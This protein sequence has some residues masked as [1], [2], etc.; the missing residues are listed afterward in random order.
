MLAPRLRLLAA[1]LILAAACLLALRPDARDA[2]READRLF[3][4]GRYY[5]ALAAYESLASG[6]PSAQLRAG[7][8]HA[9]RGERTAAERALRSA[10]Q[11]GLAPA[12]YHLALLYLGRALADDGRVDLAAST[13]RLLEDCRDPA[14]C[15]YVAPG[16]AL[17]ADEAMARGDYRAAAEGHRAALAAPLPPGW[18]EHSAYRLALLLAADAPADAARLLAAAPSAPAPRDPL[19]APLLPS[20]GDGPGRLAAVLAA[21]PALRPQLLGQLY[22]GLGLYDLAEAQFAQVDPDGPEGLAAA[23]Y[24][25]YARWRA[26]DAAGGLARLEELVAEHPDEPGARML[27]AMAYLTADASDA[28]R[29]QIDAV[30]S[31]APGDPNIE[32][33]WASWHA[34][35]REYDQAALAYGRALVAA[36]AEEQGTYAL[37]AARFH[38]A[39]TYELCET[40][41]PLAERAAELLPGD[42]EA[43]STVAAHRY[44]CGQFAAAAEAAGAARDAGAGPEAAYYLGVALAALGE[45][46]EARAA[47]I[48]AAN[49]APASDWRRRAETALSLLP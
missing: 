17:A 12:D 22:V 39:T 31:L 49:L 8:V 2:L 34:A 36:P 1:A 21:D 37:L 33:A 20:A 14:A 40:G 6:L 38:L 45:R 3:A 19:L 41:L 30:A 32:L 23:A 9:L 27:L 35:R 15:A 47:L 10:M 26:G 24:A 48:S 25:A 7:M 43:L 13:W 42:P 29:D 4:A 16:R 44:H 11:R 5:E 18:A 28:A 46:D